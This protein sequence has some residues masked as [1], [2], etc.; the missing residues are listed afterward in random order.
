[1]L[2]RKNIYIPVTNVLKH[3]LFLKFYNSTFKLGLKLT[4]PLERPLP[5]RDM[6]SIYTKSG[7][8]PTLI[9][10]LKMASNYM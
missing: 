7:K 2:S 1:M 5:G 6:L 10:L 4:K 8:A 9:T 3:G